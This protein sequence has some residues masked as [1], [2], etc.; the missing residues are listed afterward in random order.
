MVEPMVHFCIKE[1]FLRSIFSGF[2]AQKC[3]YAI[4]NVV[5][6]VAERN[7]SK[8]IVVI[9]AIGANWFILYP[10][11][12]NGWTI[13]G[14]NMVIRTWLQAVSK[15]DAFNCFRSFTLKK[16]FFFYS[17]LS[18]KT[19]LYFFFTGIE[20]SHKRVW[21]TQG[22]KPLFR[23]RFYDLTS[24]FIYTQHELHIRSFVS[25]VFIVIPKE[26]RLRCCN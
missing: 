12:N 23:T 1:C 15:R 13:D 21:E 20:K 18:Q 22:K 25:K 9:I 2:F 26:I 8:I 11:A 10:C 16:E 6:W 17:F 14:I 4:F 19:A 7:V 3:V 24:R 5:S